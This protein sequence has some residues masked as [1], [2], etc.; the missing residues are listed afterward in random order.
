MTNYKRFNTYK[1]TFV[2]LLSLIS[3]LSFQSWWI[4]L[5][6][7]LFV[8][9]LTELLFDLKVPYFVRGIAYLLMAGVGY[10]AFNEMF[11]LIS[12]SSFVAHTSA[13]LNIFV[14]MVIVIRSAR[15]PYYYING[16]VEETLKYN[17][18]QQ[19]I[20]RSV[21][22]II[23][24]VLTLVFA[25]KEYYMRKLYQDVL[26]FVA[27]VLIYLINRVLFRGDLLSDHSKK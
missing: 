14:I 2:L 23:V 20:V 22:S 8:Y 24:I 19:Q 12:D 9:L 13:L 5:T 6:V 26:L 17:Y 25:T 11:L 16:E 27:P 18:D 15:L 1:I 10:F 3:I 21:L 7:F 4:S